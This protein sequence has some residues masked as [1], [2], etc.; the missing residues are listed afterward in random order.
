MKT[1]SVAKRSITII[2]VCEHQSFRRKEN[3]Q[4]VFAGSFHNTAALS[5]RRLVQAC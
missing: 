4:A 5:V 3:L 2:D 1:T